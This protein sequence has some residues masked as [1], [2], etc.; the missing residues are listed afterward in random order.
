MNTAYINIWNKRVGAVLWD[1]ERQLASFEF[2]PGF[3]ANK[4]DIAPI[5]IPI[6]QT[7]NIHQ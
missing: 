5:K 6:E 2:E 1:T 7:G 4:L 3:S